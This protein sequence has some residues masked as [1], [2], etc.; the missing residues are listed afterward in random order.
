MKI[1]PYHVGVAAE[2]FAAAQLARFG[3]DVLVQYGA[4]Q[5]HYD[6]AVSRDGK[7][8]RVSVKGSQD[9]AWGLTQSYVA[10]ADYH[11]AAEEWLSRHDKTTLF[12]LVQFKDV[13]LN[14]LPRM[15]LAWP[16]EIAEQL[17]AE[18]KGRGDTILYEKKVWTARAHGAGTVDQI[19]SEW[20]M[21]EDRVFTTFNVF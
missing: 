9:G 18:S 15:Y 1:S 7:T 10:K 20:V 4:N 14:E 19:P 17:K 2:A 3:C 13:G 16:A 12:C 21:S 8:I 6:L 5:P 11:R